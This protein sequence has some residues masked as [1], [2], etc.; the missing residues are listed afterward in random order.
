MALPNLLT[1]AEAAGVLRMTPWEVRRKIRDGKIP[2][3]KPGRA[4][5]IDEDDLA[6]YIDAHKRADVA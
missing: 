3:T 6:A 1:A 4:W 5:L 2:A